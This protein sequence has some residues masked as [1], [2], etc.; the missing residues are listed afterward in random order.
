MYV[1]NTFLFFAIIP[2]IF[3]YDK[4]PFPDIYVRRTI[5]TCKQILSEQDKLSCGNENALYVIVISDCKVVY[6]V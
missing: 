5:F 1:Q 4:N 3:M 6:Y 2:R